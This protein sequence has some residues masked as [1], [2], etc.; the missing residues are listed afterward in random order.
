MW[1]RTELKNIAGSR[2]A[3]APVAHSCL[4]QAVLQ[5]WKRV[6]VCVLVFVCFVDFRWG[7]ELDDLRQQRTKLLG[8]CLLGSAFLCYVGAFSW[9]F[10]R[11][12]IYDMWWSDIVRRQIPVSKPFRLETLLTNEV[13]MSKYVIYRRGFWSR[14]F[15][16]LI[17]KRVRLDATPSKCIPRHVLSVYHN[18][19]TYTI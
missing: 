5:L 7:E 19:C 15:A 8:D 2:G 16:G 11:E 18:L 3:R 1:L 17:L 14:T 9:E 12:M 10:R 13:E 4:K 6:C